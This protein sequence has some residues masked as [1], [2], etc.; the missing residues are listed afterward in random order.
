MMFLKKTL[1]TRTAVTALCM[2]LQLAALSSS[3]LLAMLPNKANASINKKEQIRQLETDL[4]LAIAVDSS[5]SISQEDFEMQR[6]GFLAALDNKEFRRLLSRC[7]HGVTFSYFEWSG[8]H[9]NEEVDL[10]INWT[11]VT[12]ASLP[13]Q[14][15]KMENVLQAKPRKYL[16]QTDIQSAL[17]FA[18]E[19]M[20]ALPFRVSETSVRKGIVL[21]T[22]GKQNVLDR[23]Y[24]F[25]YPI[26]A[27]TDMLAIP[28]AASRDAIADQNIAIHSLAIDTNKGSLLEYL[29]QNAVTARYGFSTS[30]E[31]FKDYESGMLQ[32]ILPA[33]QF[34]CEPFVASL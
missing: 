8:N 19:L 10:L 15:A 9:Y 29:R 5:N 17:L 2:S 3:V 33:L 4:A 13:K 1:R 24:P 7:E 12:A 32:V 34:A 27:S 21:S 14:I 30:I 20:R 28:L 18:G 11:H 23:T 26:R 25:S 22:D 6:H 31:S 16:N